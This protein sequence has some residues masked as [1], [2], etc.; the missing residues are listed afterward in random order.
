V[1]R[2]ERPDASEN[3]PQGEVVLGTI[4]A[5]GLASDITTR[6]ADRWRSDAGTVDVLH[7]CAGERVALS[8]DDAGRD[9]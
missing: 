7:G 6:V 4:A 8:A 3:R 2:E 9:P 5:P 1:V